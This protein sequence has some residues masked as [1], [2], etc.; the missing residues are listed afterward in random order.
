MWRRLDKGAQK[1]VTACMILAKRAGMPRDVARLISL[2]VGK[3]KVPPLTYQ[4]MRERHQ[5]AAGLALEAADAVGILPLMAQFVGA[6][7]GSAFVAMVFPTLKP[8]LETQAGTTSTWFVVL[9]PVGAGVL[10]GTILWLMHS[11][12]RFSM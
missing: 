11:V 8:Y 2:E 9:A 4:R 1:D 6:V 10:S 5:S 3:G 7:A 12:C